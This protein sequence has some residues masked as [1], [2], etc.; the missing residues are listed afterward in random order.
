MVFV[1]RERRADGGRMS[2]PPGSR[3]TATRHERVVREGGRGSAR[4]GAHGHYARRRDGD[5]APYRHYAREIR[6]AIRHAGCA[7][8]LGMRGAYAHYAGG[9]GRLCGARIRTAE[10]KEITRWK[11]CQRCHIAMNLANADKGLTKNYVLD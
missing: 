8:V 3:P 7:W 6:T 11:I 9:V 2:W 5:I 1:E 4:R 10:M